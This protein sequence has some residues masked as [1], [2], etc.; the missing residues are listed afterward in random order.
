MATY[1]TRT[2]TT[3]NSIG[4]SYSSGVPNDTYANSRWYTSFVTSG[5]TI[6]LADI[7]TVKLFIRVTALTGTETYRCRTDKGTDNWGNTVDASEADFNSTDTN[8]ED[9]LS[10]SSTGWKSFDINKNNLDLA[11]TTWV[12]LS[13]VNEDAQ[14]VKSLTFA[15]QD[16][17]TASNIL[18]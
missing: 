10:I 18:Y 17:A 16:N 3:T 4:H 11:G 8:S 14:E 9:D 5:I 12:R 13:S 1:I 15:S 2:A 7:D 6:A